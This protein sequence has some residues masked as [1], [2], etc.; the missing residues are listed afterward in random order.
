MPIIEFIFYKMSFFNK[1]NFSKT[2]SEPKFLRINNCFDRM[3]LQIIKT[4]FQHYLYGFGNNSFSPV[5]R[6]NHIAD[7]SSKILGFYSVMTNNS[8]KF[9]ITFK[10]IAQL[11][12][13]LFSILSLI[14]AICSK[15]SSVV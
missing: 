7:F 6:K 12:P 11:I 8:Y 5:F 10:V 14:I 15:A 9:S 2:F 1:T 3:Q 4:I 13:S